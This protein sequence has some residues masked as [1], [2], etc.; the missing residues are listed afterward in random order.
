MAKSTTKRA[1]TQA[2]EIRKLKEEISRLQS[3]KAVLAS[4]CVRST[5]AYS[6]YVAEVAIKG[7]TKSEELSFL[8]RWALRIVA[9]RLSL[10]VRDAIITAPSPLKESTQALAERANVP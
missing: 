9:P 1:P 8:E 5:A 10:L 3:A 7:L 2:E 6:A 4:N